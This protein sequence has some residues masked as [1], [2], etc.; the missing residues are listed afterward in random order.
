M[1]VPFVSSRENITVVFL[2][3]KVSAFF[4]EIQMVK[5]LSLDVNFVSENATKINKP[6]LGAQVDLLLLDI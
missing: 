2:F 3:W 1:Y 5:I 4:A 6:S